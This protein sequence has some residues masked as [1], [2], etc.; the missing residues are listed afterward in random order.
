MSVVTRAR[1]IERLTTGDFMKTPPFVVDLRHTIG[2]LVRYCG[3]ICRL[4]ERCKNHT[5]RNGN[6]A[7]A[8]E[9]GCA[10]RTRAD[11]LRGNEPMIQYSRAAP[12]TCEN[13]LSRNTRRVLMLTLPKHNRYDYSIIGE[14]NDYAWP[15]GEAVGHLLNHEYR[16][17]RLSQRHWLGPRQEGRNRSSSAITRGAITVTG[18]AS[19]ACSICSSML[20]RGPQHQLAPRHHPD[21]QVR[22]NGRE[23]CGNSTSAA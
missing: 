15:G 7:L 22:P 4:V 20:T 23:T 2:K 19:G 21:P 6:F 8:H 12:I 13:D 5:D 1:T 9:C 17:L 18:W 16:G 10:L 3:R 14:R 11:A